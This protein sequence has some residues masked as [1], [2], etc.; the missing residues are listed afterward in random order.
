MI[1]L[2]TNVVVR[3]LTAD[4]PQ[5][6]E[7]ARKLMSS[8]TPG[9]PGWISLVVLTET[10][11]VLRRGYKHPADAIIAAFAELLASSE[12]VLEQ[13]DIVAA[14]L[15]SARQGA[16][17]ADAVI[18]FVARR[19]GAHTTMTFDARAARALD[20]MQLLEA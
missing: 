9:Q 20:G 10:H 15:D 2:D 14:A 7:A 3:L 1:G 18:S 8:L 17:F 6:T 4:D 13:P 11:W 12:I 5:Q 16:D 19:A